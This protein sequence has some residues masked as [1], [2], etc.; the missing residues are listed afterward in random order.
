MENL[1]VS[2]DFLTLYC[3]TTFHDFLEGFIVRKIFLC[4]QLGPCLEGSFKWWIH[5]DR[6]VFEK[7]VWMKRCKWTRREMWCLPVMTSQRDY[8]L[9]LHASDVGTWTMRSF[10]SHQVAPSWGMQ[11]LMGSFI[12]TAPHTNTYGIIYTMAHIMEHSMFINH[13]QE[14]FHGVWIRV[15]ITCMWSFRL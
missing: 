6:R 4:L 5:S 9:S 11:H 10:V 14:F 13:Q 12:S 15:R 2:H 3:S 7:S 8:T 1:T